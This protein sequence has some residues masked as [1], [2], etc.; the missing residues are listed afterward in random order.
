M[1]NILNVNKISLKP[2]FMSLA[3]LFA[4]GVSVP[5]SFEK[6]VSAS[7]SDSFVEEEEAPDDDDNDY[8]PTCHI[9]LI[10]KNS[11][12]EEEEEADDKDN[13]NLGFKSDDFPSANDP[14]SGTEIEN[15]E[16][17]EKPKSEVDEDEQVSDGINNYNVFVEGEENTNEPNNDDD[18]SSNHLCPSIIKCLLI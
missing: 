4:V 6:V 14:I 2:I 12:E 17:A 8:K 18:E 15:E 11:E 3:I 5:N 9:Y 7:F 13:S 10:K 1:K 16:E